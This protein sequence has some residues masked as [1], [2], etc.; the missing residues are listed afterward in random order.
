MAKEIIYGEDARKALQSGIDQLA[1]TVKITLGP[2]GRNVVIDKK[3]G[4]YLAYSVLTGMTLN[5]GLKSLFD[6]P[7]PIGE[8]GIRT[9]REETATGQSFPSGHSQA[10]A[11]L[12]W[13]I[14]IDT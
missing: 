8:E 7:R 5:N 4:E 9:L 14:R 6:M 13:S 3:F 1:D 2:K 12:S 10:S 11:S